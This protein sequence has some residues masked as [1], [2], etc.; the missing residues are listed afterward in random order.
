M[1]NFEVWNDL[2]FRKFH[3]HCIESNASRQVGYVAYSLS[4]ITSHESLLLTSY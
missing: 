1:M 4:T 2:I 3:L